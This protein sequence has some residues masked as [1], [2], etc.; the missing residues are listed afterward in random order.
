MSRLPAVLL[1]ALAALTLVIASACSGAA[2]PTS[3]PITA[4][5]NSLDGSGE[6]PTGPRDGTGTTPDQQAADAPLIVYSGTLDLEVADLHGAVE[7]AKTLIGS[8]GGN[9]AASHEKSD[10]GEQSATVTFRIPAAR[11]SEAINGL[12]GLARRVV[13]EDTDAEDV[14]AQVVDLDARIA[15]L[16]ASEA[17]LQAIMARAGTIA[18][19]LKVQA[20]L[21]KV[22]SDI[23]SMTAQRD[24]LADQAALGTLEVGFNVPVTAANVAS[25]GWDLGRE[26]DNAVATLVRISQGLASLAVWVAIVLLPV[27]IPVLLIA[28]VAL[29]LRRRYLARQVALAHASAPPGPHGPAAPGPA[30]PGPQ[31]PAAPSV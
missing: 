21:T 26:I 11:W 13:A 7:Q 30:A 23:E 16:R 31:G 24:H 1:V 29:R 4:V 15:N 27:A 14:T 2:S 10:N 25:Q 6:E 20:E 19:V 5:G 18:D 22:R 9:V 3:G 12:R 8:V 17:A 28:Y